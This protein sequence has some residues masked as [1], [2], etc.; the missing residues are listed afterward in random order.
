MLVARERR[1]LRT[2]EEGTQQVATLSIV[3]GEWAAPPVT[4]QGNW[5][6]AVSKREFAIL[7]LRIDDDRASTSTER[8]LD[9][10]FHDGAF[11]CA[12][13][14]RHDD[15]RIGDEARAVGVKNVEREG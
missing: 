3:L 9:L 7:A 13:G 12:Y 6:G 2:G 1:S 14:S 15:V 11:A 8:S 5:R 4:S 10:H